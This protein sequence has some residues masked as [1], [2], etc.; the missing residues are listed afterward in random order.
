MQLTIGDEEE[1]RDWNVHESLIQ[2]CFIFGSQ[3]A[4]HFTSQPDVHI[5]H[6][7]LRCQASI[8]I[9]SENQHLILHKRANARNKQN[10]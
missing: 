9:R 3:H 7:G 10:E 2:D 4:S 6:K 5:R 1:E 8:R